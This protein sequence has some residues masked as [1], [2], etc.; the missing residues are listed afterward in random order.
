M[1]SEAAKLIHDLTKKEAS[2]KAVLSNAH[3]VR[4]MLQAM[5][6]TQSLD[7]QKSLAGSIHNMSGD[8]SA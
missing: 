2:Y 7:I 4:T 3:V 5:V 6:S 1:V 8:R